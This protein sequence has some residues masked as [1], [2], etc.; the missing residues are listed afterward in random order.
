MRTW[1]VHALRYARHDERTARDNFLRQTDLHEGPTPLDYF[2]WA[3]C[4]GDDAIVVDTGFS[5]ESATRRNRKILRPV[6]DVLTGF[7][8]DPATVADVV[9]THLHYDHAG[10]LDL[11]PNARFH[12]QDREMSFATGRHMCA[13]C[14]NHAFDV[15]DVVRMV[16]AVYADRVVFHD[17]DAE[18]ADG[19]SLHRVGGHTDGLQMVRVSTER[20]P[21]VLASDAA[22]YYANMETGNPFPIVFDLGG[23]IQGWRRARELAGAD[24][25]IIP[26]HDPMVRKIYPAH[27]GSNGEIVALHLAPKPRA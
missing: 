27:P 24:D 4:S 26:G 6:G 13:A 14:I 9:I 12:L 3:I 7:G 22:H 10:N 23:M 5:E 15:E 1:Q 19:V 25:R 16:R 20:G 18:I 21:V 2:V 17:G 11:F 8:L